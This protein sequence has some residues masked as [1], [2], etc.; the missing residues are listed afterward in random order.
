MRMGSGVA[1]GSETAAFVSSPH[2]AVARAMAVAIA[3]SRAIRV[4]RLNPSTTQSC[5]SGRFEFEVVLDPT[6]T[7]SVDLGS[8]DQLRLGCPRHIGVEPIPSGEVELSRDAA[9]SGRAD[10]Q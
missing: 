1:A 3:T 2:P 6:D 5:R 9:M 4:R 8:E 10:H 7:G